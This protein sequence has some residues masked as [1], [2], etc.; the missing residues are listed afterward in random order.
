MGAFR[1]LL[2]WMVVIGHTDKYQDMSKIDC[3]LIAV[4]VFF[5]ISGYLMPLAFNS[6]YQFS[7]LWLK[8]KNYAFN[9]FLRIYPIY[10]FSLILCIL[11]KISSKTDITNTEYSFSNVSVYIQNILLLGLNQSN[12]W[13]QY[14]RLNNPAWS[15][16]IELQYYILVPF[17]LICWQ[18][19]RTITLLTLTVFSILSFY[20]LAVPVSLADID[21]SLL[22]W[23][24]LFFLGFIYFQSEK[25]Q[26]LL[27]GK[28]I[29]ALFVIICSASSFLLEK[30]FRTV[31]IIAGFIF[32][33]AHLLILQKERRFGKF[34]SR[35]GDLSYPVYILHIYVVG[36]NNTIYS[37]F[38]DKLNFPV[39]EFIFLVIANIIISTMIS[40]AAFILIA[41]P[42]DMFRNKYKKMSIQPS[43]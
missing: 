30:E 1:L 39:S 5:F 29:T 6:N 11:L 24:C 21:R 8:V 10:W 15:L 42:I 40:Y 18:Q 3:G 16:D 27:Q 12:L 37:R 32:V 33:A 19:R 25:L 14:L 41:Q 28:L 43:F 34:D 35:L 38:I 26:S 36:I 2:A 9:R 20:L 23:S 13:G 31:A 7:S 4:S 17:I 22:A